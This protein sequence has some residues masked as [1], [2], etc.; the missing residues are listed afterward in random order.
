MD[1]VTGLPESEDHVTGQHYDM[2]ATLVDGLTKFTKFV[3]CRTTM[4]AEQLAY[5]LT[6]EVFADHGIPE[7]NPH[8]QGQI[9]HF[10]P[11]YRNTKSIGDE[12]ENVNSLSPPNGRSDG[13]NESNHGSLLA[14]VCERGKT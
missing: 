7:Q 10:K 14:H 8:R 1:F 11:E 13:K 2:I 6:E 4:T 5:M 3:P 9:V 12:G